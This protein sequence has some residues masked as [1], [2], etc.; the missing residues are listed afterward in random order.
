MS[1]W[2]AKSKAKVV[3]FHFI[4]E[5]PFIFYHLSYKYGHTKASPLNEVSIYGSI[6]RDA[7]LASQTHKKKQFYLETHSMR[8]YNVELE[9]FTVIEF[10]ILPFRDI[11]FNITRNC[12]QFLII[13][14]NMVMET[15]LPAKKKTVIQCIRGSRRIQTS[16]NRS[17]IL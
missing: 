7:M 10:V 11:V 17:Q 16:N 12:I 6:C 9:L 15:C 1:T 13:T 3:N 2:L 5:K 8:L 4:Q 14:N